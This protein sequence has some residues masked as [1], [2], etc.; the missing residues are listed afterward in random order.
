[1]FKLFTAI[2]VAILFAAPAMAVPPP[3]P[4]IGDY[5]GGWGMCDINWETTS[6][7]F[8]ECGVWHPGM[9]TWIV[10]YQ[11]GCGNPIGIE[12]API[13]L[14]LWV[15]LY[16]CQSYRFTSYRWHRLGN[17]AEEINFM[18]E[19]LVRSN[20]AVWVGLTRG[21]EDLDKLYF[22]HDIFGNHNAA[23]DDL[24]IQW[25]YRWGEGLDHPPIDDGPC[26]HRIE[27]NEQ[28]NLFFHIDE[29]CDHWFQWK[30]RFHLPYHMEDGYYSLTIAGCPAP[31][32]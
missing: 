2:V 9:H 21:E 22:R 4:G 29:P 7:Y 24:E 13:T 23:G 11:E 17:E 10:E 8:Q 31:E 1:M 26:W 16:A 28:G 3:A 12:Y 18:I 6:G 32:L 14:E 27:P 20:S 5:N 15:E 30:G 25:T 19:G